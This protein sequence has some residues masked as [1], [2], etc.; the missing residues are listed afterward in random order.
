MI[1][2]MDDVDRG[3]NGGVV[4]NF[5]FQKWLGSSFPSTSQPAKHQKTIKIWNFNKTLLTSLFFRDLISF[6]GNCTVEESGQDR[7]FFV[8]RAG[9]GDGFKNES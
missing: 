9:G 7:P 8:A 2:D 1:M 4:V 6:W 5:G 3:G